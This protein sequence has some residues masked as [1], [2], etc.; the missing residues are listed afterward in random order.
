MSSISLALPFNRTMCPSLPRLT[1][2]VSRIDTRV[3]RLLSQLKVHRSLNVALFEQ[4][5]EQQQK[6]ETSLEA[7][8]HRVMWLERSQALLLLF[9][10]VLLL[11]IMDGMLG[12]L[13]KSFGFLLLWIGSKS[14]M[15]ASLY[16]VLDVLV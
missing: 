9:T 7:M 5:S 8:A 2:E 13:V 16:W 15:Q 12:M 11:V 4:A 10:G 6:L 1:S 14:F 3:A